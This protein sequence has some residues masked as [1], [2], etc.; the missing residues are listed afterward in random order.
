MSSKLSNNAKMGIALAALVAVAGGLYTAGRINPPSGETAGTIAPADRYHSSQVSSG[1]ITLGDN[2][3]PILMQTDAFELMVHDP[4][5]GPSHA[6][7]ASLRSP[8]TRRR[9]PPWPKTRRRSPRWRATRKP[10][11]LLRKAPRLPRRN[12]W[13]RK[14][15]TRR[16]SPRSQHPQAFQA[17]ARH[18]QA[19]A[20]MARNP[21]AFASYARN[22]QAFQPAARR[23]PHV[24]QQWHATRKRLKRSPPMLKR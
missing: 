3:V 16:P 6:T 21:Q 5:L 20:A 2:A 19:F 24:V 7:R 14:A 4:S 17:L 1:D 11:R 22:A 15:S 8:R 13:Q 23:A 12:R 10:S 18:P 9:W